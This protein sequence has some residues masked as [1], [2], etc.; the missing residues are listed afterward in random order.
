MTIAR[1]VHN[2]LSGKLWGICGLNLAPYVDTYS[3]QMY[4]FPKF[5][6]CN[7]QNKSM[8]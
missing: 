6:D 8:L 1:Y 3:S 7:N 2:I 5:D 4:V